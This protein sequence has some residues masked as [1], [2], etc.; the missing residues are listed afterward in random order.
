MAR[1]LEHLAAARG[2]IGEPAAARGRAEHA[3]SQQP[4]RALGAEL[5]HLRHP[6]I[7]RH[8]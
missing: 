4:E 7:A 8:W 5:A 2:L 1:A 3:H 6:V